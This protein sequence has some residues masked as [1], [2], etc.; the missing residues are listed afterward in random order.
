[1]N[2]APGRPAVA[3]FEQ[4][5]DRADPHVEGVGRIDGDVVDARAREIGGRHMLPGLAAVR[6][7]QQSDAELA[8]RVAFTRARI[9]DVGRTGRRRD[10]AHRER[11]LLVRQRLPR[12][13]EIERAPEAAAGRAEHEVLG[14]VGETTMPTH[15]PET[16]GVL[17]PPEP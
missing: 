14:L 11:R 15:R 8:E 13:P 3:A 7:P 10:G 4:P 6:R 2:D 17:L 9:D 16:A 1:L 12:P 5:V